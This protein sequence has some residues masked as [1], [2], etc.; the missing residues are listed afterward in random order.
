MVGNNPSPRTPS[1]SGGVVTLARADRSAREVPGRIRRILIVLQSYMFGGMERVATD[2]AVELARRGISVGVVIPEEP[3]L[4]VLA[5]RCRSHGLHVARITTDARHGPVGVV[6]GLL[7]FA[8]LL[9]SWRPDVVHLNTGGATGGAGVVLTVRLTT[10][11][12]TVVTEHD[13]PTDHPDWLLRASAWLRDHIRHTL[14]AVSRRNAGLRLQRLPTPVDRFA[15]VINGI[16][17]QEV[18][19]ACRRERR[20]QLRQRLGVDEDVTLLG[21]VVRLSDGKGLP[22]LI[23]A[24]AQLRDGRRCRLALVGDGPLRGDLEHLVAELDVG[25]LVDFVGF[26]ADPSPYLDALDIFAL[27]VPAG[28]GSIALLEAMAASLPAVITFCGPEEAI[29]DGET[30]LCAPPNDPAGL[31]AVLARLVDDPRLRKRL[32]AQAAEH[33]RTHY[34]VQ[35]FADDHLELYATRSRGYVPRRLRVDLPP[36]ARPG[37]CPGGC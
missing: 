1:R 15:A 5:N 18:S 30:G 7:R 2:L 34:S 4:D 28:T 26:Q 9:R 16:P 35:R 17:I 27:A 13:V 33:I 36:I 21:C 22:D 29:V 12:I 20:A 31:A 24:F 10:N 14:I 37:R 25:H 8:R 32:G 11:A 23:R 6:R 3:A 19:P